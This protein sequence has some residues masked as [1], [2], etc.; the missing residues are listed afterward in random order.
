MALKIAIIDDKDL[1]KEY[2][3]LWLKANMEY[4]QSF[5][6]GSTFLEISKSAFNTLEIK[7]PP[8]NRRE[9]FQRIIE[10]LFSKIKMNL[11]QTNSLLKLRDFL[12]PKLMSGEVRVKEFAEG[13][14]TKSIF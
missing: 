1:T 4:V 14:V 7:L 9:E 3:Y 13:E 5:S 8:M 10:P 11:I 2:I 6:N 12:L